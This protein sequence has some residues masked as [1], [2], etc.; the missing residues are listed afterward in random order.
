VAAGYDIAE[1][2]S[3]DE[4]ALEVEPDAGARAQVVELAEYRIDDGGPL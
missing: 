4:D 1:S 3:D 2:V